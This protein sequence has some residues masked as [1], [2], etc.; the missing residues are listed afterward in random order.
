MIQIHVTFSLD[1]PKTTEIIHASSKQMPIQEKQRFPT[2]EALLSPSHLLPSSAPTVSRPVT[3]TADK[4]EPIKGIQKAMVTT[5]TEALKI[6]AFG[7]CDEVDMSQ[8]VSFRGQLK[9]LAERRG[10][11]LSYMPI[12]LKVWFYVFHCGYLCFP[13]NIGALHSNDLMLSG[14]HF[15]LLAEGFTLIN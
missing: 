6:P 8:L 9:S 5:M 12:F 13:K 4:T 2:S 1:V 10:I 7:Y 14:K 3:F 15:V 11:R